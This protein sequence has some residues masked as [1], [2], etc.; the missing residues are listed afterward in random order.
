VLI[1][2][3]GVVAPAPPARMFPATGLPRDWPLAP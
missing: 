3:N 2:S 1:Q